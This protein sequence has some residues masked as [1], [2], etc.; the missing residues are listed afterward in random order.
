[1][2]LTDKPWLTTGV[3]EA[4][5]KR[6]GTD[7]L[8]DQAWSGF[9]LLLCVLT[10]LFF[11]LVIAYIARMDIADWKRLNEPW[12]LWFNTGL[13]FLSSIAMSKA[14]AAIKQ[15][16]HGLMK[17]HF[18]RAGLL[19]VAFLLGQLIVWQ[20][21]NAMGYF[22]ATNP[23]NTFFYMVTAI[24]GFHLLVG[25]LVWS[26]ASRELM[27][28]VAGPSMCLRVDICAAYWHFLLLIWLGL[29]ALLVFT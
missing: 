16:N 9:R 28:G 12:L 7:V 29:F 11:I 21:Y 2:F 20:Q 19:T 17:T 4:P 14:Q 27:R 22:L 6:S 1:M 10:M 5:D 8:R 26:N 3:I 25:L 18:I 13:L 23:A 15:G 24:H